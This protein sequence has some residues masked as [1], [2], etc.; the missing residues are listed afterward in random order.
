MVLN[1]ALLAVTPVQAAGPSIDTIKTVMKKAYN[2]MLS[3]KR[4]LGIG[5]VYSEYPA[6]P[7]VVHDPDFQY[8]GQTFDVWFIPGYTYQSFWMA[9]ARDGSINTIKTPSYITSIYTFY[10]D[11]KFLRIDIVV[12]VAT[13]KV[14]ETRT[15]YYSTSTYTSKAKVQVVW[16]D[17][18][19][20]LSNAYLYIAGIY[21][22]KLGEASSFE[23]SIPTT[24]PSM[25]TSIR[26][27]DMVAPLVLYTL[28]RNYSL[29]ASTASLVDALLNIVF[30]YNPPSTQ[31]YLGYKYYHIYDIYMPMFTGLLYMINIQEPNSDHFWDAKHFSYGVGYH[32][33]RN[34]FE[35]F[36]Y[37][38]SNYPA[39]P[40]KSKIVGVAESTGQDGDSSFLSF[41]QMILDDPLYHAWKGLYYAH[42]GRYTDALTEWNKI[43]SHW[44][45]NGIYVL[46]Q[47]GY[48]TVR[49][50]AAVALGSILAGHGKISWSTVDD[51]AKI[52][53][54]LQWNGTGHY[55]NDGSTI[56]TIVKPDHTGGF[57]VSYGPIGS[58][59]YVPF[60]P[61]L[62][63]Y[64]LEYAGSPPEYAGPIPTNA[65]TTLLSMIAL[66]Q[67]AYWR[68]DVLPT[69]LLS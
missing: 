11:L 61:S 45:G 31:V 48:S 57:L 29:I 67:Y 9:E 21:A 52:L 27:V 7:V 47:Q 17:N 18:S 32:K 68:Y 42:V 41:L 19:Y 30:E 14:E 2:Y 24:L 58:Y 44:D 56:Y 35:Q 23:V 64:V 46:N 5:A 37:P 26:H 6:L 34:C 16:F 28:T 22:G 8:G 49:L 55:T 43:V 38:E 10:I 66:M 50:A 53:V 40:Y 15:Y 36:S 51:M 13:L 33:V 12:T 69:E 39:Y 59:G 1:I 54:Q 62:I 25:R 20:G 65:E 60:R 4:D 3:L 63:E